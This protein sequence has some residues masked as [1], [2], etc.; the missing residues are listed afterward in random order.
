MKIQ[1]IKKDLKRL[2][3]DAQFVPAEITPEVA[4]G[5]PRDTGYTHFCTAI[6]VC[7]TR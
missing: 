2:T 6:S 7:R 1:L 3:N 5:K 4:G